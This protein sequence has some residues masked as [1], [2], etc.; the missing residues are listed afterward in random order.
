[1]TE[2]DD[3]R[4]G[5]EDDSDVVAVTTTIWFLDQFVN[6]LMTAAAGAA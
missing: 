6:S 2:D 5:Q 1:M 4:D 3:D